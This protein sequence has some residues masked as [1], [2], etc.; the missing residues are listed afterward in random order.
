M[1]SFIEYE[2]EK[3]ENGS[4][5]Y[6]TVD[7][8]SMRG[9]KAR[10]VSYSTDTGN[11][12]IEALPKPRTQS[13]LDIA[14]RRGIPGYRYEEEKKKELHEKILSILKLRDVRFPLPLNYELEDE[15]FDALVLSYRARAMFRDEGGDISLGYEA[16]NQKHQADGVLIGND[17]AATNAGITMLGYSGC[18][19]SSALETLFRN[20]PQY[21]IHK[22]KGMTTYPQ[23][24]YLVVQC[25]PH[26]NFRGLYK[27]IG[28]AIDRA[29]GN[30]K[31]VY[32]NELD[33]GKR[34]TLSVYTDRV[35]QL[36]E[37]FAIGIIIFDE[38]QHIHFDATL[39][40][41]FESILEL[42]NKTKVAF[43]VVGTEDA[44]DKIFSGNLRESRRLGAEIHAD[45]YC[46]NR[47]LF[48][49]NVKQLFKYQWFN[50]LV[51]PDEELIDKLYDCTKGIIDQLIG[52]YMYMNIDYVRAQRKPKVNADYVQRTMERHYPG[53]MDLLSDLKDPKVEA[54]RAKL[55]K[56]ANDDM[57]QIAQEEKRKAAEKAALNA[58]KTPDAERIVELKQ[59]VVSRIMEIDDRFNAS[60]IEN[61][62][63]K[64]LVSK[65][66]K[67]KSNDDIAIMRMTFKK[68]QSAGK[69]DKRKAPKKKK[70]SPAEILSL[71]EDNE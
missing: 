29:L 4:R 6:D 38:I 69:T 41:S 30:V 61:M 71:L 63:D 33:A 37:K 55:A 34:G 66:G 62:V 27:N 9:V 53:M 36:I 65:E 67:E 13:E 57:Q 25:P 68:L 44:Y 12:Y 45:V 18:G 22:G 24:V 21:I 5:Q 47:V 2:Y 54:E 20:Y 32:E 28:V 7:Y 3:L 56:Q 39:E 50:K 58:N 19:K 70:A 35:R 42:S 46:Q 11:P 48:D 8:L 15:V 40:N 26:S 14:C 23:I 51:E 1:S 43:G 59:F 49:Y 17:A 60:T 52:L 31:P 10:Y 16:H 64:V